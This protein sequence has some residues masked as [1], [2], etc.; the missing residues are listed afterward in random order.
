MLPSSEQVLALAPDS[1]AAD[2]G[3]K[4]AVLRHWKSLGRNEA[5]LWGECEGSALYQVR[6]DIS[7]LSAKCSCP[8]RKFPCKHS[9]GMLLLASASSEAFKSEDPPEWVT[10]WIA[11]RAETSTK[12]E[13]KKRTAAEKPVDEKSQAKRAARRL[14]R[15]FEGIDGLDLWMCDMVRNG[16]AT[17]ESQGPAFWEKQ[18]AR[19]VDAQAPGIASRLRRMGAI[20]GSDPDWP[21]R[22]L[23][24]LGRLAL[25]THALRRLDELPLLLQADIRSLTG[26]TVAQEEVLSGNDIVS[27]DWVV[28][29]QTLD[30][31]DRIR[32]QRTWLIGSKTNRPALVLQFSAGGAPMSAL[33]MPGTKFPGELAFWPSSFPLR[34][35]VK[36]RRGTTESVT[37]I[38]GWPSLGEFLKFVAGALGQQPWIDRFPASLKNVIPGRTSESEWTI[39]DAKGEA[40]PLARGEHWLLLALSGGRPIDLFAEWDGDRLLPVAAMADG[41]FHLLRSAE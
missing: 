33:F 17:V 41:T 6:V 8:S 40:L 7:D 31:E 12:K 5:A 10:S 1:S 21:D 37:G 4:L 29:G 32:V 19:M 28:L 36:D 34:A 16:L 3:R 9:L 11:K 25:L 38:P 24:E 15:V 18:A 27:D 30:E 39:R 22:L 14:D 20:V 26:F 35:I 13:E 23:A 2:A